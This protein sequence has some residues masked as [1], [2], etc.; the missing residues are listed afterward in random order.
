[1]IGGVSTARSA[2]HNNTIIDPNLSFD[3]LVDIL[4]A[5]FYADHNP[6]LNSRVP[7]VLRKWRGR[8]AELFDRL[9]RKYGEHP[10]HYWP[11]MYQRLEAVVS[12]EVEQAREDPPSTWRDKLDVAE[13]EDDHGTMCEE[14]QQHQNF[15][16]NEVENENCNQDIS[17]NMRHDDEVSNSF[18][19][20]GLHKVNL[21][22]NEEEEEEEE[23][24]NSSSTESSIAPPSSNSSVSSSSPGHSPSCTSNSMSMS[25]SSS[26]SISPVPVPRSPCTPKRLAVVLDLDETL[27]H[28]I[29]DEDNGAEHHDPRVESF[30][31]QVEDERFIVFKRPGLDRFLQKASKLYDLYIFTAGAKDYA[32]R[33]VHV[34]GDQ[35]FKGSFYREDCSV[36]RGDYLKDLTTVTSDG[37]L[38]R[39]VL[40]DNNPVSFTLQPSN[41][42]SIR[43]F[44]NDHKDRELDVL[45]QLLSAVNTFPDVRIALLRA[46]A[47]K[48]IVQQQQ[49]EMVFREQQRW[50]M[51]EMKGQNSSSFSPFAYSSAWQHIQTQVPPSQLGTSDQ[52]QNQN[53]RG[54]YPTCKFDSWQM[55]SQYHPPQQQHYPAPTFLHPSEEDIETGKMFNKQPRIVID[56]VTGERLVEISVTTRY[57]TRVKRIPEKEYLAQQQQQQQQQQQ[58]THTEENDKENLTQK[59]SSSQHHAHL[60]REKNEKEILS[61]SPPKNLTEEVVINEEYENKNEETNIK[62]DA[63]K[64]DA[65][66]EEKHTSD[67]NERG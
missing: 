56:P 67:V 61:M 52:N 35:Y 48:M 12:M 3:E 24:L 38:D 36:I 13:E 37:R 51:K 55:Q 32:A 46:C 65:I 16:K 26:S 20:F 53:Q 10:F 50:R 22:G 2:Q 18:D 62:F 7:V 57:T 15:S 9:G 30:K 49:R 28:S 25:S 11:E 1:M 4:V 34:L 21:E 42:I 31:L 58:P 47:N 59:N 27:V 14:E 54:I 33:V 41:G 44:Y 17:V 5:A 66:N 60:E 8:E 45:I 19:G 29:L 43:N 64:T 63:S 39:I 23:V 6:K 40:V